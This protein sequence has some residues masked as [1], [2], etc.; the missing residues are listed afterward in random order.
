MIVVFPIS[1]QVDNRFLKIDREYVLFPQKRIGE[2]C[3][4][5]GIPFLDLTEA[6]YKG[7]GPRLFKG[8]LHLSPEGNDI[9]AR[10]I[11]DFLSKTR[12][13]W[14]DHSGGSEAEM[15]R[16]PNPNIRAGG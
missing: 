9:A 12:A 3:K 15:K 7:G 4:S 16:S 1:N 10:K 14:Y 8:F 5:Y 11:T 6:L 13:F 2:I